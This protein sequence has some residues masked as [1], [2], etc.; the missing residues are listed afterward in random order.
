MSIGI[1]EERIMQITPVRKSHLLPQRILLLFRHERQLRSVDLVQSRVQISKHKDREA[2][3]TETNDD[4][5]LAADVA[6]C[7]SGLKGLSAEDV[8]VLLYQSCLCQE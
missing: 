5:D 4:G 7:L 3:G 6:W 1:L 2:E 8:A